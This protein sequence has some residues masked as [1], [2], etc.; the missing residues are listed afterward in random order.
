MARVTR[1]RVVER[2]VGESEPEREQRRDVV[3]VVPPIALEDPVLAHPGNRGVAVQAGDE[4]RCR[5][6]GIQRA[7][8]GDRGVGATR[9]VGREGGRGRREGDGQLAARVRPPEQDVRRRSAAELAGYH[10]FSTALTESTHGIRTGSPVLSTTIVFGF[11]AATAE[12]SA[13]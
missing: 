10:I 2:R 4:A 8:A 1:R 11:A 5:N 7:V 13:S 3:L 12:M 9:V 6:S